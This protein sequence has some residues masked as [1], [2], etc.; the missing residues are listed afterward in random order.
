MKWGTD[1]DITLTFVDSS[2]RTFID[3]VILS[4]FSV[5][6]PGFASYGEP[7]K[8]KQW[9]SYQS[10]IQHYGDDVGSVEKYG[11]MG[12]YALHALQGGAEVWFCRLLP[13]DAKKASIVLS[14]HVK[15][16]AAI[17]VFKRNEDG[18]FVLDENG[19]KIPEMIPNPDEETVED[20][21]EI[22]KTIPGYRIK[23]VAKENTNPVSVSSITTEDEWTVYPLMHFYALHASAAGNKF[24]LKIQNRFTRDEEVDDGRRYTLSFFRMN[25]AGVIESFDNTYDFAFNP[26]AL[27]SKYSTLPEGLRLVY[28]N[29]D[30]LNGYEYR[31]IQMDYFS[32]NYTSLLTKLNTRFNSGAMLDIDILSCKDAFQVE[33]DE[34]ILDENNLSFNESV[35][36]LEGGSDG[37]LGLG[38]TVQGADGPIVVDEAHIE[39]TKLDL[40]KKYFSGEIDVAIEDCRKI[41]AGVIPDC[42]YPTEIKKLLPTALSVRDDMMVFFDCGITSN[43]EECTK[44]INLIKGFIDTSNFRY[45]IFPH[46]GNPVD[47]PENLD[48]K[49]TQVYEAIWKI[50]KNYKNNEVFCAYAGWG[51]GMVESFIPDW[52]ISNNT[53]KKR[54]S[55]LAVNYITDYGNIGGTTSTGIKPLWVDADNTL[56]YEKNSVMRS[57]RNSLIACDLI[58]V[59][60]TILI[61]HRFGKSAE[62]NRQNASEELNQQIAARYPDNYIFT[63]TFYQTDRNKVEG[64]NSVHVLFQPPDQSNKWDVIVEADRQE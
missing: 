52:Y 62:A 3:N 47:S 13:E 45:A 37:S 18:T 24:G 34:L 19:D 7:L 42:N 26:D 41:S 51:P 40:L 63:P 59:I 36:F 17:P 12:L 20:T 8:T 38:N 23:W 50:P 44:M 21:P 15:E 39:K 29:R 57:L 22:Q 28:Q 30:S 54:A 11:Y 64:V 10:F 6:I 32:K 49:V 1:P 53:L 56:Y 43:F 46:C 16:E 55:T 61:K 2:K 48:L 14:V 27:V 60:R 58:R 31:D 5:L 25:P 9:N 4:K 33:Y 35:L